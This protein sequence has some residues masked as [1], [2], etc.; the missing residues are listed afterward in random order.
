M[1]MNK[2]IA[3]HTCNASNK[4]FRK[5]LYLRLHIKSENGI[6]AKKQSAKKQTLQSAT[7]NFCHNI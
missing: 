5:N 4:T 3:V 6:T 2:D 1:I 7:N